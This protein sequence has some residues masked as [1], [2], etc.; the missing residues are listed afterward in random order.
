MARLPHRFAVIAAAFSAAGI[1]AGVRGD[2]NFV[3]MPPTI[4]PN[5]HFPTHLAVAD[6]DGDGDLDIVV[7]G[8]GV[9][10][11]AYIMWNNGDATFSVPT[12]IPVGGQTDWAEI[13]DLNN[14]GVLDIV[15][16]VRSVPSGLSVV[17][18][19]GGGAFS[20]PELTPLGREIRS[21]APIDSDNDGDL[22]LAA[23]D[24]QEF[25]LH[26]FDNDG[27][28][29]FKIS[30]SIRLNE[31]IGGFVY[32]Q[33]VV[34][35]DID[36]D[37]DKDL[38]VTAI[39]A[40]RIDVVRNR[41]DGTFDPETAYRPPPFTGIQ[42]GLTNSA[43]GDIDGDGDLD[44]VTP[45]IMG[46]NFQ[47]VGFLM[48]KLS[49]GL[50][51]EFGPM[52][53]T[54]ASF[55]GISWVPALGDLDGDGDLDLAIGYGLPGPVVLLENK[56][57]GPGAAPV[58]GPPQTVFAGQ[59][60][61]YIAIRDFDNDGDLDLAVVESPGS[62][63]WILLNQ[64]IAGS[65]TDAPGGGPAGALAA[66]RQGEAPSAAGHGFVEK[67]PPA[68]PNLSPPR[69]LD[70]NGDAQIDNA[71]LAVALGDRGAVGGIPAPKPASR[72]DSTPSSAGGAR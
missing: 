61:R 46:F 10:G 64:A 42:P 7:P 40:G 43:L 4:F 49:E 17:R 36:N 32:P 54:E 28:G 51:A 9:D 20:P 48:N 33:Q 41:G 8:R 37:G 57:P 16:A 14:D 52:F 66:A 58:F 21:L 25:R 44:I 12:T 53:S 3:V 11:L 6:L 2:F 68:P 65:P 5:S 1:G 55:S 45:W 50:P 35:G 60:A 67:Q 38:V 70:R 23:V 15:L 56:T 22:D 30:Q 13:A 26:I 24:Y 27:D 69:L 34:A 29:G 62:A 39:G 18:G 63:V 31:E 19:L 59:F 72:P 47:R 71:D